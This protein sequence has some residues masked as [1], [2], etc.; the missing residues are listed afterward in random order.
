MGDKLH[1]F[2]LKAR[3]K[4]GFKKA[5]KASGYTQTSF[6]EKFNVSIDTVRNW[7]QGRNVPEIETLEK[8][9]D[10]FQC[11]MGYLFGEID[12][13]THNIQFIQDYTGLS[14]RSINILQADKGVGHMHR[15]EVINILLNDLWS[16]PESRSTQYSFINIFA[17][18]LRFCSG[19]IHHYFLSK[20]GDIIKDPKPNMID[21][22]GK[23]KHNRPDIHFTSEQLEQMYIMEMEDVLKALK[24]SYILDKKNN[25]NQ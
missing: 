23:A 18:Y 5:R 21:L 15:I 4:K 2:S 17:Q 19:E 25:T 8:L 13:K 12:C 22:D 16:Q 11:D 9:C 20:S 6:A 14:E 24:E 7:E 1:T 10:F 3:F